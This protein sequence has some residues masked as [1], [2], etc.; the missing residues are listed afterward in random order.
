MNRKRNKIGI[1]IN[2]KKNESMVEKATKDAA[3]SIDSIMWS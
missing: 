2:I 3:A 1:K